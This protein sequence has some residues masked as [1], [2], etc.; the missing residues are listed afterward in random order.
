M[1]RGDRQLPP[2]W[3]CV[4]AF[5]YGASFAHLSVD[6]NYPGCCIQE[7][8]LRSRSSSPS[9]VVTTRM[10]RSRQILTLSS[11]MSSRRSMVLCGH[12][13]V[14]PSRGLNRYPLLRFYILN[15]Q[16]SSFLRNKKCVQECFGACICLLLPVLWKILFTSSP[17]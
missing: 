5:S 11:A 13:L 2:V 17:A 8:K 12:D 6:E 10:M 1:L 7:R 15:I 14:Q 16:D 4:L 3:K 9:T